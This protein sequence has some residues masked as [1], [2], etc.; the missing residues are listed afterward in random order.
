MTD[1]AVD[2][3]AQPGRLG[4]TAAA[5]VLGVVSLAYRTHSAARRRAHIVS[6]LAPGDDASDLAD[7]GAGAIDGPQDART[8][9]LIARACD[10]VGLDARVLAARDIGLTPLELDVDPN[11]RSRASA[12]RLDLFDGLFD[13]HQ[14]LI[15]VRG[16]DGPLNSGETLFAPPAR[17]LRIALA[18][19]GVVGAG[20]LSRLA[21]EP[22]RFEV[23]S[24]LVRDP[25][26]PRDT[27]APRALLTTEQDRFFDA[28][29]DVVV[30][31]LS[32][33][34][35]GL[36]VTRRALGAGVAAVSANKQAVVADLAGLSALAAAN[37]T[38]LSY[39]AA[40]GGGCQ[41]IETVREARGARPA[42]A[43]EA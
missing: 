34:E 20:V 7:L 12:A 1:S 8:A 30:D 4:P 41:M 24:I 2:I 3:A 6:P 14:T 35:L 26:K 9:G 21:V 42:R 23:V 33:G 40:V 11:A 22:D 15:V 29:P 10:R 18:G 37:G 43:A 25:D 19:F 17:P 39:A 27:P 38:S 5:H 32:S 16:E 28:G 31:V 36:A 13:G